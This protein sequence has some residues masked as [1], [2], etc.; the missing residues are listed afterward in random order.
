VKAAQHGLRCV[1]VPASYR[2]RVGQSKITG[3]IGGSVRAGHKILGT[4]FRAA[5]GRLD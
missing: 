1:E 2:R 5:L 4:I 3:T